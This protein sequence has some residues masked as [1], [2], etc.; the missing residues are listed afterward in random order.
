MICNMEYNLCMS[1]HLCGSGMVHGKFKCCFLGSPFNWHTQEMVVESKEAEAV[2]MEDHLSRWYKML[3]LQHSPFLMPPG[4]PKLS[5]GHSP[6]LHWLSAFG[7]LA[8]F[9]PHWHHGLP[10]AQSATQCQETLSWKHTAIFP[11]K[12]SFCICLI[13]GYE[14]PGVLAKNIASWHPP[15]SDGSRV[16]SIPFK[17]AI[18]GGS[19]KSLI[20]NVQMFTGSQ[21]W[22]VL[23]FP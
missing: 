10:V 4:T 17:Q 19:L 22:P 11:C 1:F 20:S 21:P 15:Q 2:A 7:I 8:G 5:Q 9:H 16:G 18:L 12:A 6:P 3:T 13:T 23:K 14:S